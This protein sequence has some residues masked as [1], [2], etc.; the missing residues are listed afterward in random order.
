M[1]LI[2]SKLT[3][4]AF[5][6]FASVAQAEVAVVVHPSNA[7]NIDRANVARIFLGK[8]KSFPGA[9]QAIPLNQLESNASTAEFNSKVLKKSGSQLKAYWSKLVFT[10]KG[11]PPKAITSDAEVINLVS[12]NPNMIGY[13]D[14]SAVTADVK[15]IGKF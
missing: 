15:V 10:G 7:A 4:A 2:K 14:S 6:L 12:S 3:V 1:N 13:V 11:T 9:G 5:S 8:M